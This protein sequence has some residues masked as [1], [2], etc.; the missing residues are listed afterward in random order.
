MKVLP[1]K[2]REVSQAITSLVSVIK[3]EKGCRRCDFFYSVEDENEL[4]LFGEWESS[5]D[6]GRH[7]QSEVFKVL[8][9]AMSLLKNPH[10][11][12]LYADLPANGYLNLAGELNPS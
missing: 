6:L 8:L 11:L 1:E 3:T 4:C 12:K 9:G 2:R 5:E 7:L 10:E